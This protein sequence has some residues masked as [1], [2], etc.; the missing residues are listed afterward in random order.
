MET[1]L[2]EL[3]WWF[4]R[5]RHL[6]GHLSGSIA[7]LRDRTMPPPPASSASPP[8]ARTVCKP[9]QR[10][11]LHK[12]QQFTKVCLRRR[13]PNYC[14]GKLS[15][16]DSYSYFF[17]ALVSR[18]HAAPII[19]TDVSLPTIMFFYALFCVAWCCKVSDASNLSAILVRM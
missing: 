5:V 10:L 13:I 17:R 19:Y 15:L 16:Q 1:A 6:V 9:L 4:A 11:G 8:Y 2:R 12:P 14:T 3:I 18:F 7:P